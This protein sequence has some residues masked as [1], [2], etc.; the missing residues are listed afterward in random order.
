MNKLSL[1]L[2]AG[3]ILTAAIAAHSF[4]TPQNQSRSEDVQSQEDRAIALG[5]VR[6]INTAEVSYLYE[7]DPGTT[8][9]RHRYAMWPD[10]YA[11]G[12]LEGVKQSAPDVWSLISADGVRGYK[13]ALIVSP[14][15]KSYEL[16]LHDARPQSDGFSV[17]TDQTGLIYTGSP[18]Q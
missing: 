10:L 9:P 7:N 3:F 5:V 13:L 17:F 1:I 16:A 14:D 2:S 11:S 6:T 12:L 15:G 4:A 8:Q 18:L